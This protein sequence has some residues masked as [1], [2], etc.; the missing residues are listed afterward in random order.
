[1]MGYWK[2]PEAT[3]AAIDEEGWFH[4]GDAGFKDKDG[5]FYT[6]GRIKNMVVGANGK[7]VFP[8][9]T[10]G[11]LKGE[12]S[13][14]EDVMVYNSP[15][16]SQDVRFVARIVV[17]QDVINAMSQGKPKTP[18]E[19]RAFIWAE[20]QK[21]ND[22]KL[23]SYKQISDIELVDELAKTTTRKV[24]RYKEHVKPT[25][26]TNA[27]GVPTQPNGLRDAVDAGIPLGEQNTYAAQKATQ[28]ADQPHDRA[29]AIHASD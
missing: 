5:F 16:D 21:I 29:D 6:P 10:E 26:P 7:N 27:D 9:E 3:A 22:E 20:V 1:M 11:L 12:I 24:Q 4:T 15:D 19:I 8:E 25:A 14:I 17:N 23:P 13:S 2:N 28:I 18:E